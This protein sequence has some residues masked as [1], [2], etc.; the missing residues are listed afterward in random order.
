MWQEVH[1]P[2]VVFAFAFVLRSVSLPATCCICCIAGSP[3]LFQLECCVLCSPASTPSPVPHIFTLTKF[4]EL[5]TWPNICPA[6]TDRSRHISLAPNHP[7]APRPSWLGVRRVLVILLDT[8]PIYRCLLL[9]LLS[10]TPSLAHP[11]Y[12]LSL[13]LCHVAQLCLRGTC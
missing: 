2:L 9:L 5:T 13:I 7:P 1:M 11:F 4:N 6:R 12:F 3:S 8:C 10:H